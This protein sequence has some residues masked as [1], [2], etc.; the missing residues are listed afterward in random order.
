LQYVGWALLDCA[1]KLKDVELVLRLKWEL[2]NK[3]FTPRPNVNLDMQ[4][5]LEGLPAP[6]NRLYVALDAQE[7]ASRLL[8][9][10]AFV[11]SE[12][13]VGEPLNCQFIIQS[14]ARPETQSIK[15]TEAK[16]VFEGPLK[17]IHIKA[18]DDEMP[19][20]EIEIR[21]LALEDTSRQSNAGNRRVS[22][23]AVAALSGKGCLMIA[24]QQTRIF[25]F[26]VTPREP[27]EV[28]V[29]SITLIFEEQDFSLIITNSEF[30]G[31]YNHWWESK[32]SLPTQRDVGS[33]RDASKV[34]I[35]PKPPKV[36][37]LAK[38]FCQAYYTNEEI[39]LSL[40]VVNNEEE[41][42]N[43][44]IEARLISPVNGAARIRWSDDSFPTEEA[45]DDAVHVAPS[46]EL[47]TIQPSSVSTTSL[48]I[49][50]TI[51]ALD[52][53]LEVTVTYNLTPD[54]QSIL[55]K[56]LTLDIVV[57][58][59]FEANYDL[60]PKFDSTPWPNFFA[61]PVPSHPSNAAIPQGLLQN[62]LVTANLVSF[63]TD[64]I[65]IEG[66]LLTS[67]KVTGGAICSSST[68]ILRKPSSGSAEDDQISTIISPEQSRAFDFSLTVQ[69]LLLGDRETV[70]LSSSL[71]IAW[72]RS[73][74]DRVHNT[75]LEI[76]RFV[77][78]MAEPRVLVTAKKLPS[79]RKG[80]AE[81][82][83]FLLTY[84]I[85]NP[86]MHLLTFNVSME[87]SDDFA[88]SGPKACSISLIPIS[89][90][91][92]KYRLMPRESKDARVKSRAAEGAAGKEDWVKVQL[93]VVDAYFNQTLRVQPAIPED[94]GEERVKVDKKGGI[95]LL[96]S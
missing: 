15:P 51:A 21:N 12:G 16:I 29:A 58:R 59:P 57:I 78:P 47:S 67:T 79:I 30:E 11:A 96:L 40:E 70:S 7:A 35:L 49:S 42:A 82:E 18:T 24:P 83:L 80:V 65:V 8:S 17:P 73:S 90:Q 52:H 53:E 91:E 27:G 28:S 3:V 31:T 94:G 75:T 89:K 46:E 19:D 23:G 69:K 14:L 74:S 26:E 32:S 6:E 34:E 41:P 71:E 84:V 25:G 54:Q 37:I 86:S 92:V 66:I 85:E 2:G 68:G 48:I 1:L 20:G 81:I 93:N 4:S 44:S 39:I 55:R 63:A 61:A 95:V 77:I 33:A 10:F 88:F 76:P 60:T 87:S 5:A 9:S 43:A 13:H 22:V 62:H 36:E 38:N 72:R 64:P 56:V 50:D 45:A